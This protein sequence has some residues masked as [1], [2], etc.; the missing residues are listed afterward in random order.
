MQSTDNLQKQ[1]ICRADFPHANVLPAIYAL[2]AAQN[3]FQM[4]FKHDEIVFANNDNFS[5]GKKKSKQEANQPG[6][7]THFRYVK[8]RG[9]EV[10]LNWNPEIPLK[11]RSI[12]YDADYKEL[13]T[14]LAPCTQKVRASL[15][16]YKIG[17]TEQMSEKYILVI[18]D[19][20]ESEGGAKVAI[21]RNNPQ[22]F[23]IRD[24]GSEI[25]FD[26]SFSEAQP[27]IKWFLKE[28]T[29]KLTL[30]SHELGNAIVGTYQIVR[31]QNLLVIFVPN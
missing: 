3:Y 14:N 27:L 29:I 13:A 31:S 30:Y 23:D 20:T 15:C 6:T 21:V 10:S 18:G 11:D 16:L 17:A 8:L 28:D 1:F 7:V 19:G 22:N 2:A 26:L 9:S 4:T 25:F 5:V 24:P 12:I